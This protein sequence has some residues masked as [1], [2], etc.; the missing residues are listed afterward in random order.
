MG[1]NHSRKERVEVP[2]GW[3]PNLQGHSILDLRPFQE[4]RPFIRGSQGQEQ[5]DLSGRR[6]LPADHLKVRIFFSSK[7]AGGAGPLPTS[8]PQNMMSYT[9]TEVYVIPI[10][11]GMELTNFW[12]ADDTPEIDLA[13][14]YKY[15]NAEMGMRLY[16][17]KN[18]RPD[19]A[20]QSILF[21]SRA[22]MPVPIFLAITA[23]DSETAVSPDPPNPKKHS[24]PIPPAGSR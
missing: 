5:A 21:K 20:I 16:P 3:F 13:W 24:K 14:W 23:S 2:A 18:P 22:R 8:R 7:P 11:V 10:K 9:R 17:W 12:G 15:K 6:F 1:S 4:Q 19:V